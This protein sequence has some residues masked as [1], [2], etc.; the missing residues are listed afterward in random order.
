MTISQPFKRIWTT[1]DVDGYTTVEWEIDRRFQDAPPHSFQLF[2]ASTATPHDSDWAEVGPEAVNAT[3]LVDDA[4][5]EFGKEFEH[6]WQ[7]RLR[8]PKASYASPVI[9]SSSL[10]T[11][12]DWRLVRE[13]VRQGRKRAQK[14][15]GTAGWLM[16]RRRYGNPCT[17]C[18][19]PATEE[20][21]RSDCPECSG[22]G[23]S[24]GYHAIWPVVHYADS[25]LQERRTKIDDNLAAGTVMPSTKIF[26]FHGFPSIQS[27]DV[28]IE[29]DSGRRWFIEK[30]IET[31][32][33][34]S[35]VFKI[36][37]EVRLAPFSDPIYKVKTDGSQG[38]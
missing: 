14:M 31:A 19:D 32:E 6:F 2:V 36:N 25:S 7:I 20:P 18:L 8:T 4:K 27:R 28:W 37:A 9:G 15:S 21:T 17:I 34:R 38:E 16:K 30:I 1:H 26:S 12:R 3:A 10:L 35:Y 13:M 5:R 22:T 11:R 23:V 24:T 29:R 33:H